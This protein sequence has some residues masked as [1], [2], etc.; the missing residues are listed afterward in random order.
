MPMKNKTTRKAR[1]VGAEPRPGVYRHYKGQEYRVLGIA[2]HTETDEDMVVY[3]ALY[4]E[5]LLWVRPRAM[6]IGQVEGPDGPIPRFAFL[7]EK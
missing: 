6:F 7:R 2:R 4:G 1:D 3:Q 5:F